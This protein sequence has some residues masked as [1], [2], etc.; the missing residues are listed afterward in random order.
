[1]QR[2]FNR[3][4]DDRGKGEEDFRSIEEIGRVGK[5]C[6]SRRSRRASAFPSRVAALKSDRASDGCSFV[7][8]HNDRIPMEPRNRFKI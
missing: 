2:N 4:K 5:R 7:E 6:V 3:E 1:M 8:H